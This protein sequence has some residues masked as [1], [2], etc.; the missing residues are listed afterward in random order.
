MSADS[1]VPWPKYSHLI[2]GKLKM[3]SGSV[4]QQD[5]TKSSTNKNL[6]WSF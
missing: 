6:D 5:F 3:L 1:H 2:R 4:T